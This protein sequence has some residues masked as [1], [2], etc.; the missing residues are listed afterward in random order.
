MNGDDA[1]QAAFGVVAEGDLFVA[2][3]FWMGKDRDRH[4]AFDRTCH[5]GYPGADATSCPVG[6]TDKFRP[7]PASIQQGFT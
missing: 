6:S 1:L 5:L 7:C 2:V 4:L 3:E